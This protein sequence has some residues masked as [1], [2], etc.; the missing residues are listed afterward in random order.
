MQD[1]LG[2]AQGRHSTRGSPGDHPPLCQLQGGASGLPSDRFPAH[3]PGPGRPFVSS[4]SSCVLGLLGAETWDRQAPGPGQAPLPLCRST[5]VGSFL[6]AAHFSFSLITSHSSCLNLLAPGKITPFPAVYAS[7]MFAGCSHAP[8]PR[9]RGPAPR[10]ATR[11]LRS[12]PVPAPC[13]GRACALSPSCSPHTQRAHAGVFNTHTHTHS[14]PGRRCPSRRRLPSA[15]GS[16]WHRRH[17]RS[18]LTGLMQRQEGSVKT[19]VSAVF[20]TRPIGYYPH[21]LCVCTLDALANALFSTDLMSGLHPVL[22][23]IAGVDSL[24]SPV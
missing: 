15:R 23:L 1:L 11:S 21:P 5:L 4:G 9:P 13:R 6:K 17:T 10:G 7:Q 3:L 12:A 2:Q 22:R 16:A 14:L 18:P 24:L 20:T 8:R 19:W